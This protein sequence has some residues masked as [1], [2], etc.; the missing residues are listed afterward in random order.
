MGQSL[1]VVHLVEAFEDDVSVMKLWC[2]VVTVP[3]GD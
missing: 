3:C 2:V 1:N